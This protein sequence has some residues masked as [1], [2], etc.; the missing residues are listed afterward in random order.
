[1]F[2]CA[3]EHGSFTIVQNEEASGGSD[4]SRDSMVEA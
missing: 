2:R 3:H 1:M 4:H